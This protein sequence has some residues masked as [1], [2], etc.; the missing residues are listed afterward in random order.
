MTLLTIGSLP[1]APTKTKHPP[2]R[3]QFAY[4]IYLASCPECA[5]GAVELDY[6]RIYQANVLACFICGWNL[7]G[8]ELRA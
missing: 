1:A 5:T 3:V 8:K 6:D 7:I 4:K 2:K